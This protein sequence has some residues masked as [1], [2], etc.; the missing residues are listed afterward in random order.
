MVRTRDGSLT[1]PPNPPPDNEPL[2]PSEQVAADKLEEFCLQAFQEAEKEE[3][4]QA[5]ASTH[6][7]WILH[8]KLGASVCWHQDVYLDIVTSSNGTTA[9][10]KVDGMN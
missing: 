1:T 10:Q 2:N 5:A 7:H 4:A 9:Q 3:V 8:P 6:Q